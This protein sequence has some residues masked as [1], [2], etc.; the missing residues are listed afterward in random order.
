[1]NPKVVIVVLR[2]GHRFVRDARVSTHVCLVARAFGADGIVFDKRDEE[3]RK[4]IEEVNRNWG[5]RFWVDFVEDPLEYIKK[6]KERGFVVHLTMYGINVNDVIEKI[7]EDYRKKG[8]MLVIVG[9][10][11][12]PWEIYE[13]SDYNVAIGHQPHSEIAALAVFLDRFFEGKELRRKFPDA[14][15]EIIPSERGKKV[16]RLQ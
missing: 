13:I 1:M 11:K 5:G 15:V 6:F 16:R 9:A 4:K 2:Y 12:V 14:R 7:K 10:E 8:N 3:V